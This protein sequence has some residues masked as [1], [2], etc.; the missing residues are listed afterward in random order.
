MIHWFKPS[1]WGKEEE[2]V[3]AALKSTWISDGEYI[4][5]FEKE[6]SQLLSAKHTVTVNN[7]TSALHLALLALN[8]GKNDEVIVPGYTFAAPVN[9]LKMVGAEP[10]YVDV[11]PNTWCLD[12]TKI[13]EAITERT[14]A[15][16]PVHIYGNVCNMPSI[17]E[18]AHRHNLA[19]IEDTAEAVFSKWNAQSAGTFGD[20][21]CFS[22]QATK[23]L[24][25]G[26][27]GAITISNDVL[28]DRARLIRNHGMHGK[29]R[30]WHYEIGHNF[31]LT[32]YQAALGC[33]Q[34][35]FL[36]I[37]IRNKKRVDALYRKKLEGLEEI[38]FQS[39]NSAVD[40]V[41]WAVVIQLDKN[42]FGDAKAVREEL[43]AANIETRSGFFTF[44]DMPQ[45]NAPY[46]PVSQKLSE[47]VISLPSYTLISEEEID[48]VCENIKKLVKNAV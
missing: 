24:T 48:Y 41:V 10:V 27:G 1:F 21:G 40:P 28:A 44:H 11:D 39:F 30:Y 5:Q 43:L 31:R 38:K 3:A 34:I 12:E 16:I 6:F 19:V 46:L 23:T 9:M 4:V 13:E 20:I 17:L 7:G 36:D 25:M 26:E 18:I 29:R 14:K 47:T 22:F 8:I 15:I 32:N 42:E 33:S 2:Y 37:I 35:A 45:Y